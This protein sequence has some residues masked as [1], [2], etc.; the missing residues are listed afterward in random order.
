MGERVSTDLK[1][2]KRIELSQFIQVL[3][4]FY[5]SRGSHLHEII[6]SNMYICVC[7]HFKE[8]STI[9]K[10]EMYP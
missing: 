8:L 6:M 5:D 3:L 9:E 1:S 10:C 2:S 4:N 7:I